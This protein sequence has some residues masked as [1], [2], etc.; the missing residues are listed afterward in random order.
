[1][2]NNHTCAQCKH[3]WRCL[4]SDRQYV[5]KDFKRKENKYEDMRRND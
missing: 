2:N 3:K 5:C 1:M 4:E